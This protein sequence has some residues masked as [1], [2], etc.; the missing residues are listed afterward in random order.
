[1]RLLISSKFSKFKMHVDLLE[2]LGNQ[3]Q[4]NSSYQQMLLDFVT[5]VNVF[6]ANL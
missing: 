1:M 6:H 3:K 2:A 4:M 5:G